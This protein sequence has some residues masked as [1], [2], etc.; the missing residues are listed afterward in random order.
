[1]GIIKPDFSNLLRR[2]LFQW[3]YLTGKTPWD[4]N[5]TPPELVQLIEH[6]HFPRGRVL[7]LGCGTGTNALYLAQRGF[8]V[9]GIDFASRAIDAAR[10]KA[11]AAHAQI[12]FRRADVLAPGPF[13]HPFD[14]ILDIGCF[15][16]LDA[17]A[18]ARYAHNARQ[19]THPGSV[20][21]MYA[22]FPRAF[23]G[24]ELGITRD[25]MEKLFGADFA[26]G[27]YADDG[28]SAWYRWERRRD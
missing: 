17:A 19:W 18:R 26:R 8:Q 11:K 14:L 28:E 3:Q 16:G 5:I 25:E 23:Y 9:V 27:N 1:M 2:L 13:E 24:L 22:F 10:R 7:E 20:L 15:H 12:E 4:T 6:E 21:L